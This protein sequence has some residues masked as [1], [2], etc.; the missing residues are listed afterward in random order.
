[1]ARSNTGAAKQ[2]ADSKL[3]VFEEFAGMNTQ[4][5]RQGLSEKELA[6]C[7]NIQPIAHN[8]LQGVP[9][10][11]SALA[12]LTGEIVAKKFYATFNS[13]D[14]MICFCVSGAAYGV[15]LGTGAK[16]KFANSGT[17]SQTPDLTQWQSQ[18]ILIFDPTA[19]YSTWD[20]TVFAKQ[21]GVSPNTSVTNGGGGYTSGAN[22][23]ITGGAGS[24]ATA[25]ATVVAGVVTAIVL[26]NAGTGYLATDTLTVSIT[27]VGAGSGATGTAHVWP[28]VTAPITGA[29]AFG[30]VWLGVNRLLTWTGT[31][32]YDDFALANASGSSTI[33]DADLIKNITAIRFLNNYL[34]IF[35]DNSIKQIGSI[36]V[37]G[38]ITTFSIVTLS[39][40]QG[41]IYPATI[42]SF[43]RLVIF[44]NTVGVFAIFGASV[45]KISDNMDGI[46]RAVDFTQAPVSAVNDISNIHTYLL[47]VKYKD[48]ATG[49]RALILGFMNKKWFVMS[50]GN[51]VTYIATAI[52]GGVTETFATSGADVTQ[53]LQN[54]S[55]PVPYK[56][57]TA[58]SHHR[59]PLMGKRVIRA[60]VAQ[61]ASGPSDMMMTVQSE[62]ASAQFSAAAANVITLINN[63]GQQVI[64]INNSLAPVTLVATGFALFREGAQSCSGIW[65]GATLTGT[66]NGIVINQ[67][68]LQ[69]QDGTLWG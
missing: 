39:S 29:A 18:R 68:A 10:P 33:N 43:N 55:T 42:T 65:L 48:P 50:Q 8:W 53:I 13:I 23:A 61:T 69:Y 15:N 21:G 63:L 1:M 17:F 45:E 40:D 11:N 12:T 62:K 38:S 47:L 56:I 24:G 2:V 49:P 22:V 51:G 57:I 25:T 26:T 41:T 60:G 6:W 20:G 64:P 67:I 4:S 66:L 3:L 36:A 59:E 46:F 54:T 34:Y 16:T 14:W 30:R 5:G 9:G 58:L 31:N 7:E 35:G 37:S 28:F 27:P 44:A 32:G 52:I 19:G